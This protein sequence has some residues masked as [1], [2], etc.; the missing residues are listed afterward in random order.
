M[1]A[2]Y[3]GHREGLEAPLPERGVGSRQ[4]THLID[5]VELRDLEDVLRPL[6]DLLT[7]LPFGDL[8]D[9]DA[10][11][12]SQLLDL[13]AIGGDHRVEPLGDPKILHR[14]DPP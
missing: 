7:T 6:E 2:I 9:A 1:I 5:P 13:C 11:V 3:F 4:K 10:D 14:D 8:G 12:I